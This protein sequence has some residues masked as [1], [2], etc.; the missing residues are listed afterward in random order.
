VDFLDLAALAQSYNTT[1]KTFARGNFNYDPAGAVD[2]NDLVILAQRYNTSLPAPGAGATPASASSFTADWA[3]AFAFSVPTPTAGIPQ[4][5]KPKPTAV[6]E[7]KHA[8]IQNVK[9]VPPLKRSSTAIG[10]TASK[11]VGVTPGTLASTFGLRPIKRLRGAA[12]LLA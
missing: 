12:E 2:F 6:S 10:H 4:L 8:V 11:P 5:S 7:P 9:P 3:A 1:G